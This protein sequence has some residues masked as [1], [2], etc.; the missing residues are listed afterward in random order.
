M[1]ALRAI[2][3]RFERVSLVLAGLCAAFLTAIVFLEVV[4]RYV[5]WYSFIWSEEATIF[6]FQW[7]TFL[8]GAVALRKN[9]HFSVDIFKNRLERGLPGRLRN[10]AVR[11]LELVFAVVFVV[12]GTQF[13]LLSLKRYS[14]ALGIPIVHVTSAVPVSGIVM[15]A[16]SL[17][18]L[19]STFLG[20][21]NEGLRDGE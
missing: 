6:C 16:F 8:G 12:Y 17:E 21:R 5:L 9:K 7:I 20:T 19:L 13:A 4:A 11:V 10:I 1:E 18:R 2:N 15:M 3:D 14:Y